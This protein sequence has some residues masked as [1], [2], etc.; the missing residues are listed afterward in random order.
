MSETTPKCS[1]SEMMRTRTRAGRPAR[2]RPLRGRSYIAEG[3]A[4]RGVAVRSVV[5]SLEAVSSE[6][7]RARTSPACSTWMV[8]LCQPGSRPWPRTVISTKPPRSAK[9]SLRAVPTVTRTG[10]RGTC[11]LKNWRHPR[12][13]CSHVRDSSPRA[14]RTR[15]RMRALRWEPMP[16]K[17]TTPG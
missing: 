2:M 11:A 14:M 9:A 17:P 16:P 8:A 10:W 1:S 6:R 12:R 13:F 4:G 7:P 3:G 5:A 15:P